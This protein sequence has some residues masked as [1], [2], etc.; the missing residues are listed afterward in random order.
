[1]RR[2]SAFHWWLL[3][4]ILL[5]AI[6]VG[7]LVWGLWLGKRLPFPQGYSILALMRRRLV[8]G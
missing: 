7:A 1:M 4:M 8:L 3:A 2:P 6:G 5:T